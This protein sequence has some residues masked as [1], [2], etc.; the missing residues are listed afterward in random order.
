[1]WRDKWR[2]DAARQRSPGTFISKELLICIVTYLVVDTLIMSIVAII[3]HIAVVRH[4]K[5][6]KSSWLG[7][8]GQAFLVKEGGYVWL[9]DCEDGRV[10]RDLLG[11]DG[12]VMN[13]L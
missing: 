10:T 7:V 13:T 5:P 4:R 6:G 3:L 1:V 2:R 12:C 8:T 9:A 11:F